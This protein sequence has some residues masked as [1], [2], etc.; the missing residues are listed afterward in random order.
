MAFD[1]LLTKTATPN[2][3]T[4]FYP[5]GPLEVGGSS[6]DEFD[7]HKTP[8][9]GMTLAVNIPVAPTGTSPTLDV[10]IDVDDNTS[11]SSAVNRTLGRQ[12]AGAAQADRFEFPLGFYNERYIR[13]KLTAGGTNPDY[14]TVT[15]GIIPTGKLERYR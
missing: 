12:I 14:G 9:H 3:A 8:L 15:V 7:V 1:T 5:T 10:S 11:F 4:S 6:V 2:S 13:V